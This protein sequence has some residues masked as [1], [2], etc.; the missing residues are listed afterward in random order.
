L[1]RVENENCVMEMRGL[2]K[3][4]GF[5]PASGGR[6][7]APFVVRG[8]GGKQNEQV[9]GGMTG[10]WGKRLGGKNQTSHGKDAESRTFLN[11]GPVKVK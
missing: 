3:G 5:R 11:R 9:F 6:K 8:G 4:L 1:I 10:C 2:G 7:E